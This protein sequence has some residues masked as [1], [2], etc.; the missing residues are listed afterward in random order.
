MQTVKYTNTPSFHCLEDLR[1]PPIDIA[2]VHMG[3]EVCKP[4]HAFSGVHDEYIIHFVLSGHG[5]YSVNGNTQSL[6]PG[7]MFLIYPGESVVYCADKNVPWTYVWV[8]FNGVGVDTILKNCG[9]SKSHLVLPA[10]DIQSYIHCFDDFFE[11][12]S[13]SFSDR[14]Y[15]ESVLLK[16]IAIL[17]EHHTQLMVNNDL[18][19]T[20]YGDNEYVNLAIDYI[21]EMYRQ[22]IS[23][24]D[25]A[26]K[27]GITRSHLNHSFQKELNVSV[28]KFLID[29]RMHKA[30]N[31]L[32]NTTLTVKEIS[33]QVG[34]QDQLVFSK[35][36]KKKFGMSPK[37]Y[38]N[39]KA[40]LEIRKHKFL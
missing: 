35:A 26:E 6:D 2:L 13:L 34:Y 28:Q 14:L 12:I 29:F 9:F 33:S 24:I 22:N 40:E 8:G 11:H 15:R 25:I 5:F 39:Y 36:F 17:S 20:D 19:K 37:N 30:A 32:I 23:V 3:K 21:N 10:P 1:E 38:R 18:V 31:L 4:Y 16:L 27:V 7:Q